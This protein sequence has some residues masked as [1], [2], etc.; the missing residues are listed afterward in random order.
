MIINDETDYLI[1]CGQLTE[2]ID[3]IEKYEEE[4]FPIDSLVD[5][6]MEYSEQMRVD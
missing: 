4:N 3:A 1:A 6:V 5:D 2:L